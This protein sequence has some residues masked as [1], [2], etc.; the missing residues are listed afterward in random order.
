VGPE[1]DSGVSDSWDAVVVG[2]GPNGLAAALTIALAGR[3]VLVVEAA[4]TVGGGLRSDVIGDGN[5]RDVCAAIMPFGV[6]SPF[7]G[8]LDLESHGL[9]WCQPEVQFTHPLGDDRAG[10]AFRSLEATAEQLGDDGDRW[11]RLLRPFVERWADLSEATQRPIVAVPNH[12]I[13]LAKYG[14]PGL[15]SSQKLAERFSTDEARGLLAGCAA[16]SVLPLDSRLTA[17]VSVMFATSAHAVGWPAVAGGSQC[18]ADAMAGLLTELGG[19]IRTGVRVA[20]LDDLPPHRAV[21]FDIDVRQ[22]ASIC[23]D[24]LSGRYRKRLEAFRYGPGVFKIDHVLDGPVPWSDPW[25]AR[26]GTVH[27]GGTFEQCAK[28][29]AEVASG[30]HPDEPF[31]LVAQQDVADSSRRRTDRRVLWSYTHVP[32]GSSVDRTEAVEAQIERFAPGFRD[33]IVQR[34]T[35]TA[36]QLDE[37]NPAYVGGDLTG[38]SFGGRQLFARPRLFR[39]YRT[40]NPSIFLCGAATPPGGGVHGMAGHH[41]ANAALDSMLA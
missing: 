6:G 33:L 34:H 12:P 5:V 28:A 19:E 13:L 32:A 35:T 18:L 11:R 20:T 9:R 29:E 16:H 38:G 14:I 23:G 22:V 17:A 4:D 37:Y 40:S 2:S 25:S 27:V 8:T 39:P 15:K 31:V 26:S 3:T 21:L 10:V 36:A 41:G 7:L 30:R 1:Y 24:A